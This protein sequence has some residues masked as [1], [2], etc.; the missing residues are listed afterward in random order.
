MNEALGRWNQM[1]TEEAEYEILPCC[2]SR[3]WARRVAFYRPFAGEAQLLETASDVWH[4]L[5]PRDW[6]EA[7]RSHPRIGETQ[8]EQSRHEER[9]T[10]SLMRATGLVPKIGYERAAEV[11]KK[12]ETQTAAWSAQEQRGAADTGEDVKAAFAEANREYEQRFGRIFIVCASGKTAPEML[13]ILRRRL[14]N[15]SDMELREAVEQQRQIMELR[16]RKWLGQ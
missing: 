2:G 4:K 3:K 1:P 8:A 7:F 14:Q 6:D 5:E 9:I 10:D 12:T 11:A 16:I 15:D 13:A